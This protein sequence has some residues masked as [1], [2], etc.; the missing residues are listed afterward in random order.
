MWLFDV[1]AR[2]LLSVPLHVNNTGKR[3]RTDSKFT[4]PVSDRRKSTLAR[5]PHKQ[6]PFRLS[7][8][9]EGW[10]VPGQSLSPSWYFPEL[11]PGRRWRWSQQFVQTR[12][13]KCKTRQLWFFNLQPLGWFDFR[14]AWIRGRLGWCLRR[15]PCQ[16]WCLC[17]GNS[18]NRQ[19]GFGTWI[20]RTRDTTKITFVEYLLE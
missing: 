10:L 12:F 1:S 14:S 3:I 16:R 13:P 19:S 8:R 15:R 11:C 17:L 5:M 18:C 9:Q 6:Q 20:Q 7:L 4:N 2:L